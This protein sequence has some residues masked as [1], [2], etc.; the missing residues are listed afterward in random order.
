MEA[1]AG[2]SL[3]SVRLPA[4]RD[5][6]N[7]GEQPAGEREPRVP[8]LHG[9]L[10]RVGLDALALMIQEWN[11]RHARFQSRGF[12]GSTS[13]KDAIARAR[14][15]VA[16]LYGERDA[17]AWPEVELRFQALRE[18]QPDAWTGVI[19]GA[20]HWVAYEAAEAFNAMLPDMLRRRTGR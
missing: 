17:I 2:P 6:S 19:P 9:G 13:L 8:R 11:T 7:D 18:V 15:P 12:A 16:L 14:C 1:N 5:Q 4:Q 10:E 20:G 3:T